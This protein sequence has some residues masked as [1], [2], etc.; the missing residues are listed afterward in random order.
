MP[1]ARSHWGWGYEDA[2]PDGDALLPLAQQV[3]FVLGVEPPPPRAPTP[4]D[5]VTLPPPRLDIPQALASLVTTGRM[6]RITHTHGRNYQD[7][8]RAFRGDF[9]AAPDA[10]AHPRTEHDVEALLEWA[11]RTRVALVPFGGGTNV[12]GATQVDRTSWNAPVVSV[13]LGHLNQ[14]LE[15]DPVSRS[16]RLQAGVLG[17]ALEQQLSAHGFTLRHFPQSFEFSSLGGWIATRA[18]GHYATGPTHVDDFVQSL[19]MVTPQGVM[20]TPRLPASGAGPSPDRLLLGSEGTLGI[21]TQAWMRLSPRPRWRATASVLFESFGHAV[22]AVRAVAQ[23][24]LM[25]SNC[26]LLDQR[27]AMLNAVG[28][29]Q[30]AVFILGFESADHPLQPWM[31]RALAIATSHGGVCPDGA[32]CRDDGE[33]QNRAD[34]AGAWRGAFIQAPYLQSGLVKLS[35]VVDTFETA[36]TWDRFSALYAGVKEAVEEAMRS[37]CGA[38][39]ISCRFTHAYADGPAPYFTF[40]APGRGDLLESWRIIRM[41]AADAVLR[42]GGTITHHHAVGRLHRGHYHRETPP[43]FLESLRAVK[44]RLDPAGVMNPGALL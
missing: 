43:L 3:S 15:L 25:P 33:K 36:V 24:G 34:P 1:R 38:G 27:E 4:V 26:R 2:I 42:H 8:V 31:E 18:G 12:V 14:L 40:I 28:D 20:E 35:M 30:H 29:G 22:D 39:V 41:A 13:D 11:S 6:A 5:A 7:I 19:R 32:R 10:V 44:A 17:P 23:S 21:I 9:S 37:T 16:A